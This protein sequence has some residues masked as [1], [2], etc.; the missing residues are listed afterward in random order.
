MGWSQWSGDLGSSVSGGDY[1][2][3]PNVSFGVIAGDM[4][5]VATGGWSCARAIPNVLLHVGDVAG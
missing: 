4:R 5:G 2:Q 1:P 3:I